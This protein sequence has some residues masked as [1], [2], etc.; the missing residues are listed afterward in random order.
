MCSSA[1]LLCFTYVFSSYRVCSRRALQSVLHLSPCLACASAQPHRLHMWARLLWR[2]AVPAILKQLRCSGSICAAKTLAQH[3]SFVSNYKFA[4]AMEIP[5][6]QVR[7]LT[8]QE[9][10]AR[11]AAIAAWRTRLKTQQAAAAAAA[12]PV[13]G[14]AKAQAQQQQPGGGLLGGVLAAAAGS[15]SEEDSGDE[16]FLQRH[17][18]LEMEE[19]QRFLSYTSGTYLLFSR[20]TIFPVLWMFCIPF[21]GCG[22]RLNSEVSALPVSHFGQEHPSFL[23]PGRDCIFI[24]F[25]CMCRLD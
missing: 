18:P 5:L 23:T 20:C 11:R 7:R 9:L 21:W 4:Q 15:S 17:R 14:P 6:P 10:A 22:L 2:I 19:R 12:G 25:S 3:Q 24:R 16:A 8:Q 13:A 1:L